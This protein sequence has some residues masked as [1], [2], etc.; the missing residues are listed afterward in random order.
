MA[1]PDHRL[2]DAD[3]FYERAVFGGD[4]AG[5]T[6]AE[7]QLDAV[8]FDLC[9]SRGRIQHAHQLIGRA[10]V[11]EVGT[12]LVFV[13][14]A[15]ELARRLGDSRKQGQALLWIGLFE[16]VVRE[17]DQ[18]AGPWLEAARRL[19]EQE[20]DSVTLS[21][22]LRHLGIAAHRAG[23]LDSA[24]QLLTESTALRRSLG[25]TAGVAANLVGL[26]YIA[27]VE[28]R[29]EEAADLLDEAIE[30]AGEADAGAIHHQVV[31]AR[32]DLRL[33]HT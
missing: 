5:L 1:A 7:R 19:A 9:M 4:P 24:R 30:L 16:Q 10:G 18:A 12:E 33:T 13:E 6:T 28:S 32:R 20:Q 8:D 2:T 31:A 11:T 26:A 3:R 23:A 21:Y 17:D 22:V 25:F 29:R 14:R 15:L 27:A